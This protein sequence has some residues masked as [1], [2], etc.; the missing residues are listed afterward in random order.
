MA[1]IQWI[2]EVR[3]ERHGPYTTQTIVHRLMRKE[4]KVIHR[5]SETGDGWVAICNEPVF[6]QYIHLLI[7]QM[8]RQVA[9]G[10]IAKLEEEDDATVVSNDIGELSGVFNMNA[11]KQ[12]IS[13]QL[14][15]AKELQQASTNLTILRSL[16]SDI[17]IKRKVIIVANDKAPS[18]DDEIHPD[19]KDEYVL[20]S[21]NFSDYVSGGSSKFLA[22]LFILSIFTFLGIQWKEKREEEERLALQKSQQEAMVKSKYSGKLGN[23][24][25]VMKMN[26]ADLLDMANSMLGTQ[27]NIMEWTLVESAKNG[28]L[29][30]V[31]SSRPDN[32]REQKDVFQ[33]LNKKAYEYLLS[34]ELMKAEEFLL[35]SLALYSEDKHVA[36]LLLTE[37]A[38]LFNQ[39]DS[40]S[41]SKIRLREIVNIIRQYRDSNEKASTK[42]YV[43]EMAVFHA[44]EDRE[45]LKTVVK[46]FL[47]QHP[48]DEKEEATV[49]YLQKASWT[50]LLPHCINV[51]SSENTDANF[52]AM[53]AGCLVRTS[54]AQKAEPYIY[55]AYKKNPS[56]DA[57]KDLLGWVYLDIG[58]YEKAKKLLWDPTIPSFKVSTY[59]TYSRIEFCKVRNKDPLC[60]GRGTA[61]DK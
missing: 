53:L 32:Y 61:S 24:N 54:S 42:L 38:L 13:E 31:G 45:N 1:Q 15:H 8:A 50:G 10:S 46:H 20:T 48:R 34:G 16:L 51:Y 19:D 28:M 6:E 25:E 55:Y 43:A 60:S 12:G 44:L 57:I 14:S 26:T 33:A 7:E 30:T 56:N 47:K 49:G 18:E 36:I 9:Q 40:S 3:G 41:L 21:R 23:E 39:A 27:K 37:T 5:V 59:L 58:Q 29:M 52:S 35:K 22:T 4:L 2:V 11:I 17:R